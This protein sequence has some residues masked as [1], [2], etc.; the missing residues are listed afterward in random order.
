MVLLNFSSKKVFID[1]LHYEENIQEY[2]M[3][4]D[5]I[6]G[7]KYNLA[8]GAICLQGQEGLVLTLE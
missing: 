7:K 1:A 8:N 4:I 3:G 2:R 5:V 6:N